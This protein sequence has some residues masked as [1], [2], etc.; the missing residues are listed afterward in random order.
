MKSYHLAELFSYLEIFQTNIVAQ[1]KTHILCSVPFTEYCAFR[2]IM[3]KYMVD[4]TDA[5]DG[6]VTGRLRFACWM[7]KGRTGTHSRNI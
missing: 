4:A 2:N 5:T 3:W 1:I 7:T 6:D